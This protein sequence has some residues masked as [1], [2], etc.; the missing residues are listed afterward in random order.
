MEPV[1]AV[2]LGGTH[3]RAAA[4]GPQ[5]VIADRVA[6]LT[7]HDDP[8]P[9]QLFAIIGKMR[10]RHELSRAVVGLPGRIDYREGTLEYAPNLPPMWAADLT[11][12]RL[13]RITGVPT[14]I[15]NDADLAAAG[16]AYFGAGRGYRDVVFMTVSTGIGAGAILGGRL[17]AGRR[18][19]VEI[20]HVVIDREAARAGRPATVEQLGAGPALARAAAAAGVT[21]R[22][23]E[24]VALAESGEPRLA[25]AWA[26]VTEAVGFGAVALAHMFCPEVIVIGGGLG[27]ASESLRAAAEAA[28]SA[29]GPR[30]LPSPITVV[31]ALL[32]ADAGLRGAAAWQRAVG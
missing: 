9:G 31:P 3:M 22:N 29:H 30:G 8:H 25:N 10:G 20:G 18:S 27:E 11:V 6:G 13:E 32:G 23:A 28:V 16:E 12:A 17:V 24:L 19:G 7:P 26:Q 15:A 4:V 14:A 2:D 5:G 1:L 21:E